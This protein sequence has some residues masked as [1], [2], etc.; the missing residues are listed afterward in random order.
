MDESGV[1][2]HEELSG[3]RA[4]EITAEI[5]RYHRPPGAAGYHAATSY[6][7]EC[8]RAGGVTEV[9]EETY[10]LDGETPTPGGG[11]PL[12]PA[13]EPYG[14]EVRVVTP[15]PEPVVDLATA[16][17]S[18]AWWSWPTPPGGVTTE[19]VDVGTGME[20]SDFEG[21]EVRGKVVFIGHTDRRAS[22][23]YAANQALE[24]GAAGI[25]TDYLLYTSE[26]YRTREKL[27]DAVQLL[28]MPSRMGKYRAWTCAVSHTTGQR[29]RQLLRLGPV[30]I[31]ADIRCRVFKG[32]GRNLLASIPGRELPE[33]SVYFVAHTSAATCPCANC[34]AGPAL[35]VEIARTLQRLIDS[36]RLRRPRRSIKFLF[37][38]E[39]SGSS[40]YVKTHPDELPKIK[41]AFCFDSVGH[42]QD[43]LKSVLLFYRHPDSSPSF[44]NDYFA[45][46]M[47]R[48]P[49]DAS[50]VFREGSD[51]SLV[52][53]VQAPY[54]PWSDNHTLA[55]YGIPSPLI[56]SWPDRYFHTQLLTADKT[57]PQV[58]R[59]AGV[60][61]A[62]A[63]YEIADAGSEEALRIGRTVAARSRFRLEQLATA[64]ERR[65]AG[66]RGDGS[67]AALERLRRELDYCTRRDGEAL[68]SALG[69]IPGGASP[70]AREALEA[71]VQMLNGTA[72]RL[73][74]RLGDN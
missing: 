16:P 30:Q 45:E 33:E 27:P 9:S 53:F 7:A 25:L 58:F 13:W 10:P 62:L 51:I 59:R 17:S 40:T 2:I 65:L 22:W 52:Q 4:Q 63:A 73:L 29:L 68:R 12:P 41:T 15:T 56:M 6:V 21:K 72:E 47:E 36:G 64:G 38:V 32:E 50:W 48:A 1:R 5:T 8:L 31:H 55:A 43:K 23:V 66:R 14:A 74:A 67:E 61:S 70:E 42:D 44:I 60:T 3:E 54:T 49:R 26:P 20:E 34:A 24:R 46:V 37:I 35:M 39:G 69:L 71:E 19:L 18:L 11:A 57:D 28:R